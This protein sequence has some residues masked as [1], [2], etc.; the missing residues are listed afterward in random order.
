MG[1]LE[2]YQDFGIQYQAEGHKHCRPGWVN[3][4]CPFCTG[5]PGLHL[6]AHISSGRFY[7]WRCGW[8]P[9]KKVVSKLFGIDE[10]EAGKLL[11]KYKA[12]KGR[13]Q[14]HQNQRIQLHP[15]K[16]PHPCGPLMRSHKRYLTGRGFDPEYLERE[17]ELLGTGPVSYLDKIDYKHRIIAPIFWGGERVSFQSRDVSGQAGLRYISCPQAREKIPHQKI[18]YGKDWDRKT[19]IC[20]EGITD[21]WRFGPSAFATFGIDL[22]HAQ[23]RWIA[24]LFKRVFIVF[25]DDPQAIKQAQL[26]A[27]E[28]SFRNI[29]THIKNITGDPGGMSQKEADYL[30]SQLI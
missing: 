13:A 11:I 14:E 24:K 15:H 8:K 18:L 7:C 26:L 1:I 10:R 9:A 22:T 16:L 27:S 28:L 20:V 12:T 21:V 4:P 29:E 17:W 6:G 5:N 30:V 2:L 25:D 3:V 19:G 23:V